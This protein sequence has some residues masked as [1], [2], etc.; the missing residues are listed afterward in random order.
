VWWGAYA[1]A[2]AVPVVGIALGSVI[3]RRP[4][5]TRRAC[6]I[7]TAQRSITGA[8]VVTI[9]GYTQPLA[10]VSV[11]VINTVGIVILLVLALEWRRAPAHEESVPRETVGGS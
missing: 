5:S 2:L 10:N 6:V 8:I 11:T 1:A 9:F 7:T 3:S 4:A